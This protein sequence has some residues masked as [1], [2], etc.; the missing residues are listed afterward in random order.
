MEV[1]GRGRRSGNENRVG[2]LPGIV[3]RSEN[4]GTVIGYRRD[5]GVGSYEVSGDVV[6]RASVVFPI[7]GIQIRH[8]QHMKLGGPFD[9]QVT[10]RMDSDKTRFSRWPVVGPQTFGQRVKV[11]PMP[12]DKSAEEPEGKDDDRSDSA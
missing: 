7:D 11:A 9:A 12:C 2:W 1:E 10:S 8:L 4:G 3:I 5:F 6:P